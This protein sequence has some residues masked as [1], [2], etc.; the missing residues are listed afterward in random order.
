MGD[1]RE[2]PRY[3]CHKEVWALEIARVEPTEADNVKTHRIFFR[4]EGYAPIEEDLTLFLRYQ[5]VPGDFY[6]VYPGD[7]YASIS[8]RKAF[9][10]GYARIGEEEAPESD[11]DMRE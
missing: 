9:L 2:M 4:D 3:K 8:P 10:D 7:G 1:T 6:V 5:P 11:R